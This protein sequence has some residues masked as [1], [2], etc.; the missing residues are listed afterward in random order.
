[1]VGRPRIGVNSK[2]IPKNNRKDISLRLYELLGPGIKHGASG[3]GHQGSCFDS[4]HSSKVP[5]ALAECESRDALDE[6]TD[7]KWEP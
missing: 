6:R 1:M 4:A 2:T 3:I 7:G 5:S